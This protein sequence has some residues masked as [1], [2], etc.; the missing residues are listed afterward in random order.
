MAQGDARAAA[1]VRVP[2]LAAERLRGRVPAKS[3][4]S[5]WLGK[6]CAAAAASAPLKPGGRG[7]YPLQG[8]NKPEPM[9]TKWAHRALLFA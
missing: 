2:A 3:S 1:Q 4:E 5:L 8:Q 6:G 7:P 9:N